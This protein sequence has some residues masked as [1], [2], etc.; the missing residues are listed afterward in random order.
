MSDPSNKYKHID[1]IEVGI[2]G[3]K[4]YE[5]SMITNA[6]GSKAYAAKKMWKDG[7]HNLE[8]FESTAFRKQ[9]AKHMHHYH[10]RESLAQD[11]KYNP[12]KKEL[13]DE[14]KDKLA[15]DLKKTSLSRYHI[16][17][18]HFAGISEVEIENNMAQ[19]GKEF[20]Q[21]YNNVLARQ[22]APRLTQKI[23]GSL[24]NKIKDE[25]LGHIEERMNLKQFKDFMVR[26]K[27]TRDETLQAFANYSVGKKFDDEFL[28]QADWYDIT[29]PRKKKEEAAKKKKK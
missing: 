15:E 6:A 4:S 27:L 14:Q 16:L 21:S 8:D 26:D 18:E 25:D 11:E 9:F 29:L 12:G 1:D 7:K 20:F 13:S 5:A 3:A 19:Y 22:F 10:V 24:L 23:T 2:E 17:G 28:A